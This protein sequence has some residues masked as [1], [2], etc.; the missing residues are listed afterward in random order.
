MGSHFSACTVIKRPSDN[1][2]ACIACLKNYNGALTCKKAEAGPSQK[3][4]NELL[5]PLGALTTLLGALAK[6]LPPEI[7]AALLFGLNQP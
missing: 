7:L 2:F 6:R 1:I 3:D 5:V 4:Q